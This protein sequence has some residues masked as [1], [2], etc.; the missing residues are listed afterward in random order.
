M[1]LLHPFSLFYTQKVF[2]ID[3]S[4]LFSSLDF[5]P[6]TYLSFLTYSTYSFRIEFI[7]QIYTKRSLSL[8][9]S[10]TQ[11]QDYSYFL[12][13]TC[14]NKHRHYL[15]LSLSLCHSFSHRSFCFQPQRTTFFAH[16]P[17]VKCNLKHVSFI[18][19]TIILENQS[20][21]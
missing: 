1:A 21:D 10:Q 3:R 16:P 5:Y 7:P 4:I 2:L 13:F 11:L 17:F 14:I 18:F 12:P 19:E 8:S 15:S 6:V 9:L 20:T